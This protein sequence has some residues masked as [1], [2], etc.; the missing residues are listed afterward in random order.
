MKNKSVDVVRVGAG[1]MSA[2]LG[3]LLK[4]VAPEWNIVVVEKL[5]AAGKE[6]SDPWN[7]AGTGHSGLCELNYSV[8]QKDGSIDVTKAIK[9]NEQFQ[10]SRQFWSYLV[11][12]GQLSN[13]QDFI[14]PIPHMSLVEGDKNVN[15]MRKRY[16]VLSNNPLFAG[17][18]YTEDTEVL[19]NWVPLMMEGRTSTDP[20]AATRIE[21]GTDVN[22]GAL[23][24]MLISNLQQKGVDVRYNT[25]VKDVSRNSD[26]KWEVKVQGKRRTETITARFVFLGA[27]GGSLPL[28]QKSGISESKGIG[29]FPISGLF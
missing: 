23:T 7:N 15:Y 10:V 16:D 20:I 28:L 29:G 22:F 2:T 9:I 3:A 18:E 8:E 11:N 24:N 5:D 6:S 27:G 26:G 14:M 13:P 1:I 17:M 19:K 4:E 21:T 25:K 12:S